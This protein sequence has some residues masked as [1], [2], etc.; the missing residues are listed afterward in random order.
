[1]V[2]AKA[3]AL[4]VDEYRANLGAAEAQRNAIDQVQAERVPVR[5]GLADGPGKAAPLLDATR[6]ASRPKAKSKGKSKGKAKSKAK[7]QTPTAA[8]RQTLG[9]RPELRRFR[10][11]RLE[12]RLRR[13]EADENLGD[14]GAR[15]RIQRELDGLL[16]VTPGQVRPR[17]WNRVVRQTMNMGVPR[18]PAR[19]VQNP[20]GFRPLIVGG[21]LVGVIVAIYLKLFVR[22]KKRS[23]SPKAPAALNMRQV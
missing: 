11:E 1:L 12:N 2:R 7:Q 6:A 22:K 18:R 23:G 4:A 17:T 9:D 5:V 15:M 13:M 8:P 21:A 10:I 14:E 16:G 3:R 19:K 20:S